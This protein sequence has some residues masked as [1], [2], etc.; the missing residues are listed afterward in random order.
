LS[1]AESAGTPSGKLDFT[2]LLRQRNEL[3]E[4][5]PGVRSL[6]ARSAIDSNLA[7]SFLATFDRLAA[8]SSGR[9]A[10]PLEADTAAVSLLEQWVAAA[11]ARPDSE[12]AAALLAADQ[13]LDLGMDRLGMTHS[14]ASMYATQRRLTGLGAETFAN[15]AE[16]RWV[17]THSW[18]VEAARLDRGALGTHALVWKLEHWCDVEPGGGDHTDEAVGDARDLLSRTVAFGTRA[19]AHFLIA[20]AQLDIISLAH[21]QDLFTDAASY[22][23]R[24]ADARR[25]ATEEYRAGLAIE[26]LSAAAEGARRRLQ[27]LLA[28]GNPEG[29]GFVCWRTE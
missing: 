29:A 11:R 19:L 28:G 18:L 23:E 25:T 16:A 2:A 1:A 13:L 26:S 6:V 15:D 22:R 3:E 17:Y 4:P 12:Q 27:Q 10:T 9:P 14:S 21:G 20:D 7:A 5:L 24:E 8:G